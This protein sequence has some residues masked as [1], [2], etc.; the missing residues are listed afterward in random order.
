MI[1]GR[2]AGLWAALVQAALNV[3]AAGVIVA[4]GQDLSPA[5]VGL[6]AAV[7]ALGLAVVG[8]LANGSDPSTV[9]TFA[10]TLQ[11]RRGS[12]PDPAAAADAYTGPDRRTGTEG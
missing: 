12:G 7:N 8:L 1:L 11:E 5:A 9:P 2:N 3:A 10:P 4:T 6:F